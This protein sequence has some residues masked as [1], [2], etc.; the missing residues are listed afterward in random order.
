LW[1]NSKELFLS[2]ITRKCTTKLNNNILFANYPKIKKV[3]LA[4][5]STLI[6]R[7]KQN[8]PHYSPRK[9]L[10]ILI[11]ALRFL[12]NQILGINSIKESK[13]ISKKL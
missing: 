11:T 8:K 12:P 9:P 2:K 7:L 6:Y 13:R 1:K 3:N 10:K 5:Q 4:L